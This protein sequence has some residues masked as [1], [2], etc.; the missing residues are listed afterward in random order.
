MELKNLNEFYKTHSKFYDMTRPF[1]LFNRKKAVE[2][3]NVYGWDKVIDLACGT[4]L[5]IPL[6]LK[7]TSP[8]NILGIDY[9]EAMIEKARKK[10]PEVKFVKGDISNY[11]FPEKANKIISTYSLS[12]VENIEETIS[13][14]KNSLDYFGTFAILDFYKW[15]GGMKIFYPA[16]KFWLNKHGVEPEKNL[17]SLLKKNFGKVEMLV[18]NSGYNFIAVAKYP[19]EKSKQEVFIRFPKTS[20]ETGNFS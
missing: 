13:N 4:G 11:K 8:E 6:L 17:E 12:M 20:S 19:K 1:F 3:L 5:N 2:L 15:K 10:F 9:S 7:K 14:V 18:L 16:F